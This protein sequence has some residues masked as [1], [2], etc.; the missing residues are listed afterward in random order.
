MKNSDIIAQID[1]VNHLIDAAEDRG[2]DNDLWLLYNEL[3]DLFAQ[4]G[5]Y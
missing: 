4:L 1:E 2:D 5:E 3:E